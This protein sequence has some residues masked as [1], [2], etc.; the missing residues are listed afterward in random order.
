LGGVT[1]VE[2]NGGGKIE[3]GGELLEFVSLILGEGFGGEE[4]QGAG[5]G[6][7]EGGVEDG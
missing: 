4:I 5:F 1:I 3:G 2:A 7:V 6:I